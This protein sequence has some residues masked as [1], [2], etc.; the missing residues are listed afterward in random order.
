[1]HAF[2][3]IKLLRLALYHEDIREKNSPKL[4]K[5]RKNQISTASAFVKLHRSHENEDKERKSQFSQMA[6]MK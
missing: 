1:M 2:L 4:K 5:K 6:L 3:P